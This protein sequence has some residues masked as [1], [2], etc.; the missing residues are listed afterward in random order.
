MNFQHIP[1]IAASVEELIGRTPLL[2]LKR[3]LEGIPVGSWLKQQL[4]H[5]ETGSLKSE[6]LAKVEFFNPGGSVKDRIALEIV[7]AAEKRGALKPGGTIVEATSGNTGAGLA[8]LASL[9][10]YQAVF[11]MPDK[12]SA[13]KVN[14]LRAYGAKVVVT[15]TAAEPSSPDYYCNVAKRLAET[16]PGAFL[17]NQYFTPDN[18]AAHYR[19]TG[20]EIWEQTDGKIDIFFAG[21]GTGGTI[22][23][24]ARYLKEKNPKIR[25]VAIDPVGSIYAG[26]IREKKPSAMA[27]YLVEGIG[28]DMIPGS[29][30]LNL[31]DDC[32]P[33]NDVE[34]FSATRMLAQREGLLVG[35]SCGSAFFGAAQYLRML[36]EKE[37]RTYRA[38]VLLPDSGSR[39]LSKVFNPR[40][41]TEKSVESDWAGAKLGGP[42]E[43]LPASKK[44]EG[45][46]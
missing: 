22:S 41:L 10:G 38:V 20:P 40:W 46:I 8:V 16:I 6:L 17:A 4:P 12:M 11:V 5:A 34:S 13:E 31:I 37:K 39:Y 36:E 43:Y 32:V 3:S 29:I 42:V 28:E 18:Q 1:K 9:R 7:N 26:L 15:P 30:D 23:G 21:A 19:T 45:V 44:I 33:V 27:P 25:I 2:R 35:G 24:T 14:A